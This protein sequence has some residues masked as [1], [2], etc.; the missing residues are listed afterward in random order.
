MTPSLIL[1]PFVSLYSSTLHSA[2]SLQLMIER[3][4]KKKALPLQP[5]YTNTQHSHSLAPKRRPHVSSRLPRPPHFRPPPLP[6]NG[7][8]IWEP[9]QHSCQRPVRDWCSRSCDT[10][11]PAYSQQQ[12][13]RQRWQEMRQQ[14]WGQHRGWTWRRRICR[15]DVAFFEE[16]RND[17]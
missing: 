3:T 11:Y 8:F 14:E 17:K 13:R 9:L 15:S 2:L 16:V 12:S 4:K 10:A 6:Q 7:S 1:P 5:L